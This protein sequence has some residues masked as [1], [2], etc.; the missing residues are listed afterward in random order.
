MAL[1]IKD[2]RMGLNLPTEHGEQ[3]LMVETSSAQII[4]FWLCWILV[5]EVILQCKLLLSPRI[6]AL[7]EHQG[8]RV[9]IIVGLGNVAGSHGSIFLHIP[10]SDTTYVYSV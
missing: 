10:G 6:S 2:T 9:L 5:P 1:Q 7:D 8:E 3:G 4:I